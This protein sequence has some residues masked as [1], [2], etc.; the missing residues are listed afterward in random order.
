[1]ESTKNGRVDLVSHS[2][3][4]TLVALLESSLNLSSFLVAESLSGDD[5]DGFFLVQN[6]VVRNVLIGNLGKRIKS[7]VLD[8][9]V[10]EIISGSSEVGSTESADNLSLLSA[11]ERHIAQESSEDFTFFIKFLEISHILCNGVQGLSVTGAR[12]QDTSVFS[13]NTVFNLK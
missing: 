8:Q 7:I 11:L 13:V 9:S 10:D 5:S 12:E 3:R 1:M 4:N 6:S 2:E